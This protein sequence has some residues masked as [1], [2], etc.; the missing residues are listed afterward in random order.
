MKHFLS[1]AEALLPETIKLR[2]A[3]H[4]ESELG[5]QNPLTTQKVLDALAGLDVHIQTGPS[6]TGFM[7]SMEGRKKGTQG[8]R[9]I[10]LRGDMDALPMPE[11]T[12]LE[13]AS[14]IEGRMHAC[15]H[16]AHTAMLVSAA[17]ILDKR[18]DE[19]AGTVKFMFQPGEE[20]FEGARYMIEDGLIDGVIE[21]V[22]KNIAAAHLCEAVVEIIHSYPVTVNDAPFVDFARKVVDDLIGADR[23]IPRTAPVMG[24]EDFSYVLQRI[25]G[26]MMFLGVMP[27]NHHGHKHVAP[28]HSNHMVLNEDSMA[29][30][31][32]LHAAVAWRFLEE[33]IIAA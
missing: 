18:R 19:F 31:A 33:G 6:T 29:V 10:L 32:A 11:E 14:E 15:G 28:C 16:D 12:G 17:H 2:R 9:T 21:R 22:A 23:Y 4:R 20:G 27:E 26:C 8:E 3:I 30:G 7:V 25:P 1:D 5:L 13:Y 24:A